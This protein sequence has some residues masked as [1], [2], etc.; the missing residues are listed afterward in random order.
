MKISSFWG[1]WSLAGV[2][3]KSSANS[4]KM[5]GTN[6]TKVEAY[7]CVIERICPKHL[8]K[9]IN[10]FNLVFL[11]NMFISEVEICI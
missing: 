11:N 1:Y 10:Y 7:L 2:S 6:Q 5:D 4:P 8:D 3:F 9:W